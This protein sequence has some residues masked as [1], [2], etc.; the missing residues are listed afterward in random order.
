MSA[1]K[2]PLNLFSS[3]LFDMEN[4]TCNACNKG[5]FYEFYCETLV[6]DNLD[7]FLGVVFC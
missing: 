2:T 1:L 7:F 4:G 5:V 3:I 6:Q